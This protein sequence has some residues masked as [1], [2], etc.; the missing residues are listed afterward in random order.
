MS[1]FLLLLFEI[2]DSWSDSEIINFRLHFNSQWNAFI[3]VLEH[4]INIQGKLSKKGMIDNPWIFPHTYRYMDDE[5]FLN[6][7]MKLNTRWFVL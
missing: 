1:D 6:S 3:N 5:Q 2:K 7:I 4:L